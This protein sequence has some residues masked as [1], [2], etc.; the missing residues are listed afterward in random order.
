MKTMKK[1]L[2]AVLPAL[3]AGCAGEPV[4]INTI[5]KD[6]QA[7]VSKNFNKQSLSESTV[8]MLPLKEGI[9]APKDLKFVFNSRITSQQEKEIIRKETL[10][11][12][13]LG[14]GLVQVTTDYESNDI[15]TLLTFA[16]RYE[17]Y[18]SLKWLTVNPERSMS[19]M[20]YEI[21]SIRR[22]EK[23]GSHVGDVATIDH[24]WNTQLAIAN[25]SDGQY[26]CKVTKILDAH[27]IH[28]KLSGKAREIECDT[29]NNGIST[30]KNRYTYLDDLHF[31][32][33]LEYVRA[34]LKDT[35]ELIEV[36]GL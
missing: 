1:C 32:I 23:L 22:F 16:L 3:L 19:D 33:P 2:I 21:K 28:A 36:Q 5:T 11:Y 20:P 4:A 34:N 29:L 35:K 14:D 26:V 17:G 7:F 31:A 13:L 30:G 15:T 8:K 25:H 24:T 27:T 18:F 6:K 12:H 9:V 10:N